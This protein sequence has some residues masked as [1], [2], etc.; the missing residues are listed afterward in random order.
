M[1]KWVKALL[2]LGI[3]AVLIAAI[4]ALLFDVNVGRFVGAE[5]D[6][7][8]NGNHY[9][10]QT[11]QYKERGKRLG[12]IEGRDHKRI[13]FGLSGAGDG[14]Y[15]IKGDDNHDFLYVTM[16]FRGLK[17]TYVRDGVVIPTSGTLTAVFN[18]SR[19]STTDP[20]D[21]AM[22]ERIANLTGDVAEFR[23]DNLAHN[24]RAF[25]FA[26]DHW[27]V[28]AHMP[29]SIAYAENAFFFVKQGDVTSFGDYPDTTYVCKG[30]VITEPDLLDFITRNS[31]FI[32][33]ASYDG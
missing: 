15:T 17:G 5:S 14:V 6:F 25:Y 33:P 10:R 29:G 16:G 3:T 22:F 1:K 21:I 11:F 20:A 30:I 9:A 31:I 27:P 32:L 24:Q 23:T 4:A 7:S 19:N 18:D 26:Y 12:G 28:A 2:G 8:Y 13:D